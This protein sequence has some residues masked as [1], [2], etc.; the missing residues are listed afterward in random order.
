MLSSVGCAECW[1]TLRARGGPVVHVGMVR[2]DLRDGNVCMRG[3]GGWVS[4]RLSQS[5]AAPS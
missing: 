5:L 1:L 4:G 2:L 3:S